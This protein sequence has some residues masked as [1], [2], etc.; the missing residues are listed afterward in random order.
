MSW[1]ATDLPLT[2]GPNFSSCYSNRLARRVGMVITVVDN[3]SASPI[4]GT[5]ANLADGALLNIEGTNFQASYTSGDGND[6]TL[7]VVPEHGLQSYGS[8]LSSV[9]KVEEITSGQKEILAAS[10]KQW[11]KT[12]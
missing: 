10:S 6:L 2:R 3:T 11:E 5:F 7:T 4:S 9:M 1:P 12:A 8:H